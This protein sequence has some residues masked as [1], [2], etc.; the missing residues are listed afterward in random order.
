MRSPYL[1]IKR[2][3]ISEKANIQQERY[4]QY[5]FEVDRNANKHEIRDAIERLFSVTVE[6]IRVM[7]VRGK[8]RRMGLR[9]RKGGMT[10]SWKKAIVTLPKDQSIDLLGE[11]A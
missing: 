3:V 7:N 6:S 1:V 11:G 9:R 5:S 4:N 10:S 8:K 2:P